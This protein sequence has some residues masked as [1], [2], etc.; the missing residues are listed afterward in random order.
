MPAQWTSEP[1]AVDTDTDAD[2]EEEY[3]QDEKT[4]EED[5]KRN[6]DEP[7]AAAIAAAE[8]ADLSDIKTPVSQRHL[9]VR[10]GIHIHRR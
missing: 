2:D 7:E 4:N 1:G 6:A 10:P 9:T 5:E 3:A 8:D